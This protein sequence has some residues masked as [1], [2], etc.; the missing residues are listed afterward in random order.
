MHIL[1]GIYSHSFII[2]NM[3]LKHLLN[4][5][6]WF[7]VT[8]AVYYKDNKITQMCPQPFYQHSLIVNIFATR[9]SVKM[10]KIYHK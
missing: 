2:Y 10:T 5:D 4:I 1:Y 9:G 8:T 7:H 3:L 6:S